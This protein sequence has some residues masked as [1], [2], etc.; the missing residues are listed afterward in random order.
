MTSHGGQSKIRY[1]L[2]TSWF[3]LYEK[4]TSISYFLLRHLIQGPK[5]NPNQSKNFTFVTLCDC[6]K[7][8]CPSERQISVCL[9]AVAG[10]EVDCMIQ[11]YGAH[12]WLISMPSVLGIVCGGW[13]GC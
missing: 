8:V 13:G 10:V 4:E 9:A 11:R 1:R 2:T 3:H 12:A 7:D 6:G 5:Y